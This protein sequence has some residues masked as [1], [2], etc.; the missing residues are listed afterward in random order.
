[1]NR[2]STFISWRLRPKTWCAYRVPRSLIVPQIQ[3]LNLWVVPRYATTNL[4]YIINGKKLSRKRLRLETRNKVHIVDQ[5]ECSMHTKFY[6][7]A[8]LSL[9]GIEDLV[10]IKIH[11]ILNEQEQDLYLQYYWRLRPKTWCADRVPISL[12]VPQIQILN[13]WVVPRYATTNLQ[14]I[15]NG[16]K[17]S[18]KR[19]RVEI[20]NK[21]HIV[22]QSECSM[23]TKFYRS[24][25]L[26]LEDLVSINNS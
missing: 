9:G 24:A 25:S 18:Q 20:R 19:L 2:N 15:I 12:I 10:S 3:N 7:S 17:L 6:R 8:S 16:K 21:A 11:T 22:D 13:P 4:Q 1:M 5:S 14:Y 26:S 23:H